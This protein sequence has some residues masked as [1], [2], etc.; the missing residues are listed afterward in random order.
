M[1][2]VVVLACAGLARA[3]TAVGGY[4]D[5]SYAAGL[6]GPTA[7]AFLPDG[8]MLVTEQGGALRIRNA[9]GT[10]ALLA[11]IPVCAQVEMGLLGVAVDPDFAHDGFIYLY[12]TKPPAAGCSDVANRVNEVVRVTMAGGSVDVG[13]LATI[14]T[15]IRT[16]NGNHNGGVVRVGPDGK[17]Y[18]GVGDTGTGDNQGGPGTSTNPY[19]QDLGAL[20]GKVLRVNL[21]G[22][23]PSDNPFVQTA[24][25]QPAIWAYGFRN[26]FRMSFDPATGAL[27]LADVGDATV[28]EID[29]IQRGG[30]YAWPH[31]EG[32]LPSGCERSGDVDPIFTYEH[33]G[34]SSLG[35]CIIGGS[36][37][38][39]AFG[40]AA[41]D[42]V[43]GDC[44]ASNVYLATPTGTRTGI[45]GTPAT[46][47]TDAGTPSDFVTGPDGAVYYAAVSAGEV[48][49]I[50]PAASTTTTVAPPTTTT[51]TA[52]PTTTVTTS[53]TVRPTT[54]VTTTTVTTTTEQQPTTTVTTTTVTTS[55]APLATTTTAPVP[56]TTTTTTIAPV[57]D[58]PLP[59]AVFTIRVGQGSPDRT[60]LLRI[61]GTGPAALDDPT[62][63]GATLVIRGAGIDLSFDLPAERWRRFGPPA[64]ARYRYTDV[65]QTDG[66]IRVVTIIDGGVAVSGMGGGLD[67]D[68]ADA[69]APVSVVLRIGATRGC[70]TFGGDTQFLAGRLFRAQDAPA[71]AACGG[72]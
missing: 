52:R 23:I 15:G 11:T 65:N 63:A 44:V 39:A 2:V 45:A 21:D 24:G 61:V 38:G 18:V 14:V 69:P 9:D 51:T 12:R 13:T 50:A 41:G 30:N 54:T 31:C 3:G 67:V 36:F 4:T 8:R 42:Y 28:E 43:F 34:S 47:A 55:T 60:P 57:R 68:L 62:V 27:W 71:P 33:S 66:P 58:V 70:M 35:E 46:I 25:A 1:A 16:D 10:V 5:T 22:T 72:P 53:T 6:S 7:V 32:T 26:P 19:A 59:G 64:S 48:R 37:A 20:N 49:R 40:A 29:I 17:L 56:E